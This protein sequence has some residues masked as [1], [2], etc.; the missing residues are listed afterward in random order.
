MEGICGDWVGPPPGTPSKATLDRYLATPG[1][2]MLMATPETMWSTPKVT[3]A[4]ACS[5]PP[6]APSTTPAATPA[7][8]PY[9]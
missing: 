8:G 9:W 7:H 6:S 5:S 2:R 3:V 4:T 1:A